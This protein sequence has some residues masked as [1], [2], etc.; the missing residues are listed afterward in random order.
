LFD[1]FVNCY[2]D[3]VHND[4]L[5]T[6]SDIYVEYVDHGLRVMKLHKAAGIDDIETEHLL[7]SHPVISILTCQLFNST[8]RCG[9]VPNDFHIEIIIPVV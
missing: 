3:L 6:Y 5:Q 8:L 1:E 7:Y 9:R 2:N 4:I